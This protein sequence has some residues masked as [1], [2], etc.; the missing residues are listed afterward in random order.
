[1][2]VGVGPRLPLVA[3]DAMVYFSPCVCVC[4]CVCVYMWGDIRCVGCMKNV[5]VMMCEL[6]RGQAEA[7][8]HDADGM[9]GVRGGEG[10]G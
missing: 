9:R 2:L 7:C 5:R 3:G 1:M 8:M 10:L 4:V 6:R